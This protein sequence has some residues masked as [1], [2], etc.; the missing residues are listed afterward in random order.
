[1]KELDRY[2]GH[3]DQ[4]ST[5]S[6]QYLVPCRYCHD[7][8]NAEGWGLPSWTAWFKQQKRARSGTN[9]A[10]L[11]DW[12]D[13]CACQFCIAKLVNH[14]PVDQMELFHLPYSDG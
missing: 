9:S 13:E 10:C 11:V 4:S 2:S 7:A 3:E 12:T 8:M 1:M 14:V 5:H 6:E